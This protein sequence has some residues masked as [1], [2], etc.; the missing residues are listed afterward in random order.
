MLVKQLISN[1]TP[2]KSRSYYIIEQMN[3]DIDSNTNNTNDDQIRNMDNSLEFT[4]NTS[5]NN[6]NLQNNVLWNLLFKEILIHLKIVNRK[7]II[8]KYWKITELL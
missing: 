1:K 3:D 7:G 4:K 8:L 6:K 5:Y 2:K